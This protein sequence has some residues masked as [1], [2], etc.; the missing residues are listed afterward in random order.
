VLSVKVLP[1][2]LGRSPVLLCDAAPVEKKT[3]CSF[4]MSELS[5]AAFKDAVSSIYWF[6]FFMGELLSPD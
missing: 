6:E 4:D 1:V 5:A 2:V 3:I